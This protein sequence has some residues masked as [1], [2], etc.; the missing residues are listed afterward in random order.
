MPRGASIAIRHRGP[1]PVETIALLKAAL[2]GASGMRISAQSGRRIVLDIEGPGSG[3]EGYIL[4]V[5]AQA[6]TIRATDKKG[7]FNGMQTL[8]QLF[9]FGKRASIPCMHVEDRPAFGWRGLMLDCSRTFLSADFLKRYIDVMS[10]FKL[11]VLHLHLTDDQGWRL[12]I[13]RYPKLTEIGSKFEDKYNDKGGFYTRGEMAGLVKYAEDRGITIIPEIEMPGHSIAALKSYPELSCAGGP[14]EIRPYTLT[15]GIY[16]D[17]MCPGN[18]MTFRFVEDVLTDVMELFPSKY[19]HIGGDEVPKT[20]WRLCPKCQARMKAEGLKDENELQSYFTKRI[21]AFLNSKGRR[22]I[23]WDEIMEGGLPRKAAVMSWRGVGPGT[24]ALKQGHEVVFAPTS[25][26]YFDY[27]Y[28][29][30][31]T[32]KVYA[33]NPVPEGLTDKEAKNILGIQ[34]CMWTHIARTETDIDKQIFPRLIAL[35]E[36]AWSNSPK[37]DFADFAGRLKSQLA[38]LDR[39]KTAYYKEPAPPAYVDELR[40]SFDFNAADADAWKSGGRAAITLAPASGAS[41]EQGGP[42]GASGYL[43]IPPGALVKGDDPERLLDFARMPFAVDM[44]IRHEGQKEQQYGSTIFSYG[45]TGPGGWRVGINSRNQLIF[46][47]YGIYDSE[48]PNSIA[49]SDGVWHHISVRFMKDRHVSFYVDGKRTDHLGL[50]AH[51]GSPQGTGALIGNDQSGT[52]PFV[53][54]ITQIRISAGESPG[55]AEGG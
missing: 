16:D 47:L 23:G 26:C 17:V 33:Y 35:S 24:D 54:G 25:H 30:T 39:S 12:E 41:I 45:Q 2:T 11:N 42:N 13:P 53:G 49:P 8:F 18:E 32:E 50:S 14:F 27:P 5:R 52:T 37:R 36:V 29:V 10:A 15:P 22:L 20:K 34:A 46:S 19:I 28:E 21:G 51:G 38:I 55:E 3:D 7:I 43:S 31:D 1:V 9:P 48:A 40:A 4:D 6:I 44:W